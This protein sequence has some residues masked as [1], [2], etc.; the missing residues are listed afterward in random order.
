MYGIKITDDPGNYDRFPV[1]PDGH[2]Y[3]FDLKYEASNLPW[4]FPQDELDINTT[5]TQKDN[6]K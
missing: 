5:L 3:V 6:W 2:Y 4:P 1:G